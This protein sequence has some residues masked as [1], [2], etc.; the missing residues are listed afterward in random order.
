LRLTA[1]RH[2]ATQD[3]WAVPLRHRVRNV[4]GADKAKMRDFAATPRFIELSDVDGEPV[5]FWNG[6]F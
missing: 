1:T 2:Q 3:I 4:R 5:V 6:I